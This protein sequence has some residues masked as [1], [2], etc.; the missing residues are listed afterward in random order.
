M[1]DLLYN[2]SQTPK[3]DS[4]GAGLPFL[5]RI[6]LRYILGPYFSK[7]DSWETLE[8]RFHFIYGSI[9]NKVINLSET[10]L[11]KKVL[12]KPLMGIEDSSRF[13]SIAMTL[14]H[15]VLVGT[16]I[17]EG[18]II[19]SQERSIAKVV[20]VENFK[21]GDIGDI[22]T[23]RDSVKHFESFVNETIPKINSQIGSKISKSTHI[24]PW[25]GP[26]NTHQ[27]FW[28]L[29]IHA[30]IHRNQIKEILAALPKT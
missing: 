26:L 28:L 27:W 17:R 15:I 13:W 11:N 18:L 30:Q 3:L 22:F 4:P 14:D 6:L 9:L 23:G 12:I 8:S 24:H 7:K 10:E 29:S 20:K 21:P 16:E 25:F 19:L 5:Q 1:S 2:R